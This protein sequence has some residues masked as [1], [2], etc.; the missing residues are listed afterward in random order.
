[1]LP[2]RMRNLLAA[3]LITVSAQ[4]LGNPERQKV[5]VAT[6]PWSAIG[7]VNNGAYGRCTGVL[8]G[9]AT[10][11]TAAHCIFNRRTGHFMRPQSVH[12]VLGYDRGAYRFQTTARA[13]KMGKAYD[14]LRPLKTLS[15]DWAVLSLAAPAP[16][17]IAPLATSAHGVEPGFAFVSAGFAQDR[18]YVLTTTSQCRI[19]TGEAAALVVGLCDVPKGYSG[20]PLL[21]KAQ[22][23][24]AIQVAS[25]HKNSVPLVFAVPASAWSDHADSD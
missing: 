2:I 12:F 18:P 15:A 20:G 19:R 4:A 21:D 3:G 25:G 23:L 22:R 9:R 10:A 16:S 8:I 24:I 1:M 7:Q 5:D 13:I 11:I 6:T 17:D 14:P